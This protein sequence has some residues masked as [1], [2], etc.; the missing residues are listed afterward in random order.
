MEYLNSN[1]QERELHQLQQL[2][3]KAKKSCMTSFRL[4]HSHLNVLSINDLK[5]HGSEGGYEREFASL[6][7][8]DV[9]TF[10]GTMLLNLD[11][12]EKQLDKEEFQEERSMA[13]FWFRETLLQH[14]GNVKKS[15]AERTHHK[16]EYDIRMNERQMQSRESKVVSSIALDASLDIRPINDQKPSAEVHLTAQHNVLANEQQH[17]NQSEPSYDT[18]L[19][20]DIAHNYYLEEAKKKTQ[21]KIRNLKPSVMHTT[22]LQ[23]TTNG[24]KPKPRSNNQTSRS[25]PIPK[26]SRGMLNEV[27]SRAKVQSLKSRNNIKPAKRI[28]NVNK[29]ERCISKG[30]R[31]S[32]NKF[33]VVHEK[34]NTPRSCLRWKS[35]GRIFKT[36]G[37]RCIPTGKMFIDCT[38]KV[39]SKPLNGS[40]DDITNPYEGDQTLNVS[41]CTL[42]LSAGLV[43]QPPSPIPNL[44]PTKNDWDTVF[45]PLFDEHFNPQPRAIF[46]VS[47]AVAA[48]RAVDPAG[49]PSS[50]TIDQ[51]VPSAST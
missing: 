46:S 10:T 5:R 16:R 35:T 34:P 1:S 29:S 14:M 8:Q 31:F 7:V 50:T 30:Y 40:N 39:D 2:Q 6:F 51:D 20:N 21:N 41:T 27:N 11:Q 37:L 45:F 9:Q 38:T 44:P 32:P 12:L 23:N 25:L 47:A 36:T 43:P 48:P 28:A 33:F 18:Y 42:N 15:V 22:S 13:A 17:T 24:R 3:D 49:S 19:S 26:S 4:L